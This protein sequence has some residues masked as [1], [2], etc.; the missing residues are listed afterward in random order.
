MTNKMNQVKMISAAVAVAAIVGIGFYAGLSNS[1]GELAKSNSF[2]SAVVLD[3]TLCDAYAGLPEQSAALVPGM[4]WIEGGTYSMGSD[5][6]YADEAPVHERW[7]DGFWVDSHEVTNAQ[8]SK[9][10]QETG[11]VTI[12]E[13]AP[14]PSMHSD[15]PVEQL[16]AGGVVFKTSLDS[17]DG[18]NSRWAFVAHASWRNPEGP[19]SHIMDRGNHPVVQ[20]VVEDAEAYADWAG[21]SLPSE[22]EWEYAARGGIERAAYAW[23]AELAPEGK[24]L[25]NTWQGLFPFANQEI[26][27]FAGT[28]PVGCYPAN[29]YSLYDMIGNAWE[30]TAD[31][32][33]ANANTQVMKGGSYL[34]AENY[35]QRYRPAARHPQERDL[36][37]G[38]VSFRTIRRAS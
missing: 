3:A 16:V 19:G 21:N 5:V 9:F 7:I 15:I 24:Q 11:Y 8:F 14:D 23:G 33:D 35:C 25:A 28:S 18:F 17:S 4:I 10:I 2:R 12:A 1:T 13:R 32:Y 29:G 6:H 38:H 26:D 37:T 27:G 36:P 22:A 34:C 20:I 30:L 31:I